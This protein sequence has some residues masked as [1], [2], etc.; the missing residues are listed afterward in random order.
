MSD[1]I[2]DG[3]LHVAV[4]SAPFALAMAARARIYRR[5]LAELPLM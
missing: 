4:V 5:L 1:L 2:A 3:R